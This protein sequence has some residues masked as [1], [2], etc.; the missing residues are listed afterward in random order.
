MRKLREVIRLKLQSSQS[1]RAIAR[2]CGLSPLGTLRL[3]SICPGHHQSSP[4]GLAQG[5]TRRAQRSGHRRTLHRTLR[6]FRHGREGVSTIGQ[7]TPAAALTGRTSNRPTPSG[8]SCATRRSGRVVLRWKW[9]LDS[10]EGSDSEPDVAETCH[11][12][13]K[14]EGRCQLSRPWAL[15][16][17]LTWVVHPDLIQLAWG[18]AGP[19][20]FT[21]V[22]ASAQ[23]CT[24][25]S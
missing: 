4:Q 15:E 14:P 12:D 16:S 6:P 1:G 8:P 24:W 21:F 7:L 10:H 17:T 9:R 2:S 19:S 5:V 25:D 11:W 18:V 22:H 3:P 20:E 23:E 13:L